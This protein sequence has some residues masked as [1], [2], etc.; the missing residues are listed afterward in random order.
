MKHT[1]LFAAT[2]TALFLGVLTSIPVWA[3]SGVECSTLPQSIC[4]NSTKENQADVADSSVFQ[5]VIWVLRIMTGAVG[6]AAVG[7]LIYAGVMYA[8]ASGQSAQVSQ[9]KT[10][11]MNVV[12]GL[13]AY[14][15]MAL[16]LNWLIPGGVFGS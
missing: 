4:D 10:L 16:L 9:A 12:I 1:H 7:A 5:I 13:V 11:I 15:C 6:V 8:S 14:G 2:L 3:E